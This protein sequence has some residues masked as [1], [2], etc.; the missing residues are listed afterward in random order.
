MHRMACS[1]SALG[2]KLEASG[3]ELSRGVVPDI[4]PELSLV[5]PQAW[6]GNSLF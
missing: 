6:N 3:D 5:I 1:G 2:F 4:V